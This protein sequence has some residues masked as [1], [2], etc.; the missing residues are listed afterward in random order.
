MKLT[1]NG[2]RSQMRLSP[3]IIAFAPVLAA[4][5]LSVPRVFS[6]HA[7]LQRDRPIHVWG[8]AAP[9]D[10]VTVRFHA[11]SLTA[12]ASERGVWEL[13]L[14]PES[15]GGPYVLNIAGVAVADKP[16]RLTDILVGDVWIAS[17]QSN[18]E[19]PLSGF[20]PNT[21]L[22]DG[23][24]E[25]A[26]ATH[27]DIRLLRQER[28]SSLTPLRD[29]TSTWTLCTPET[30]TKFSAVAYFFG[31]DL[32]AHEHIP[33][34]LIDTTWG[35]TSAQTW[36]SAEGVAYAN[37]SSQ[38]ASVT[39]ADQ[40]LADSLQKPAGAQPFPNPRTA[41]VLFNAMIAP[42]VPY[43]IKGAIWY[44]G[45]ADAK[46]PRN[47]G[48]ARLFPALITDWRHQWDQGD[49]PFLFVQLSSFNGQWGIVRDAQRRTL[50]L[51]NTAMA[52]ALD[53]GEHDNI[54]PPDKQTVGARLAQAA[55]GMVYREPGTSS[56]PSL[57]VVTVEGSVLRVWLDNDAGLK[58]GETG[59][60]DFEIAAIDG[61]FKS[62]EAKLETVG[63][64]TTIVVSSATVKKPAFVRY[65][66]QPWVTHFLYNN[67]NLPLGT[68]TSERLPADPM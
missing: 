37:L 52:V 22:K 30:A 5:Q 50:E 8:S 45:E 14:R 9:A 33:I 23:A 38:I 31:R 12:T 62:A 28:A 39:A 49:F 55:R 17:G 56:S 47:T 6:D 42:F 44:Q 40:R 65:G 67:G 54:H 58:P 66:W 59:L 53:L 10:S 3:L 63:D 16:I 51:R 61:D 13:W 26:A 7:V 35:G 21:P 32:A 29:Q 1:S 4:A 48:Y 2:A 25:I 60:G 46:A 15:A 19:F 41:S 64:R 20:G 34:G 57:Q 43:T 24:A 68:F 36:I 11:Q 27:P 18:M